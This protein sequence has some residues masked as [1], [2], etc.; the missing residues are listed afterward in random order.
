MARLA[1]D[2]GYYSL[3][4][5]EFVATDAS[6]AARYAEPP[7]LFDPLITMCYAAAATQRIRLTPSTIVLP[8]HDPILLARELATLDV[9]SSGRVSL[10]IGLGGSAEEYQRV[11]GTIQ[12]P[13]R[14]RMMDEY[15]QALR[16]VWTTRSASFEGRYVRFR[17]LE[18]MPKPVQDPLPIFMAGHADG[19]F[20][21]LAAY[22]QGLIDSNM[23]PDDLRAA[24]DHVHAYAREAGRGDVRFEIAR[25]FYV[26]IAPTEAEAKANHAASVPPATRVQPARS[27]AAR[28]AD[29]PAERS[30]IGTP[31]QIQARLRAYVQAGATEIC[32]IFY[33][34]DDEAAERQL[35]LFAEEVVPVL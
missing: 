33:F 11:R 14:G 3:W 6:V 35:R 31:D 28:A 24:I 8:H 15:I 20:R 30:L 23:M 16:A 18:T 1:E 2:L 5:N 34:P 27:E 4:P 7:T 13:N 25:Q 21:R 19:V 10:G 29:R 32:A 17:D 12:K 26:S 22:G 9:F